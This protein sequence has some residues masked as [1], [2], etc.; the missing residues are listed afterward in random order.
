MGIRLGLVEMGNII[1][2]VT[3]GKF[4]AGTL[5][6]S[7][8]VADLITTCYGG[9]NRKCAAAFVKDPHKGWDAI[10]KELLDGQRLQ[11]TL[12]CKELHKILEE[13]GKEDKYPLFKNIYKIAFENAPPESLVQGLV[14]ETP[15]E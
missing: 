13:R 15:E 8:G 5:L 3:R 12:A 9:R 7:C 14:G 11:G 6:E 1:K 2:A 4:P 10:E